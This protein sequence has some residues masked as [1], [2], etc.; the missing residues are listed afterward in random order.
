MAV[1]ADHAA[2]ITYPVLLQGQ[3]IILTPEQ[4]DQMDGMH[5]TT[6]GQKWTV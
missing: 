3:S 6:Y 2:K 1:E 4:L 5:K